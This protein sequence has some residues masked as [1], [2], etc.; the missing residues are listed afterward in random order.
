MI[1]N[2][3]L[4]NVNKKFVLSKTT[5]EEI[6]ST[7]LG[8]KVD[9][10][11]MFCNPLRVDN[12]PTCTMAY[13]NGKLLFRDWSYPKALDCF[14]FVMLKHNLNY[15]QALEKI[16]TDL[17]LLTRPSDFVPP[18][19]FIS[20]RAT[21]TGKTKKKL[22]QVRVQDFQFADV[23]YW[24]SYFI[25]RKILDKFKCF[26]INQMWIEKQ[27]QY[28]YRD[29][30]PAI[31]YFLGLDG[32]KDQ[33]WKVYFYK[34]RSGVRFIGNTNRINGWVQLPQF[35]EVLVIT[36]SMKDVMVLD[37]FG[38]PAIA[39]QSET[40][41]PYKE[42]IEDL[43]VRFTNIYSLYDF[44]YAGI[45]GALKIRQLYGIQPL[46]LTNGKFRTYNYEAK[47]ISDYIKMN[48]IDRTEDLI[49]TTS[50]NLGL[51]IKFEYDA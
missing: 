34:R 6:F 15:G 2:S 32:F 51:N 38:I 44:D 20:G 12:K 25:T 43:K 9:I 5:Q 31:G 21:L 47:D 50:I 49:N 37:C 29:E 33:K 24:K 39:M 46:F 22:I 40:T 1:H 30:D 10:D 8:I 23:A 41:M 18:E 36:K 3:D 48:G 42:I 14:D 19:I 13:F 4:V 17:E 35:G 27:S 26:S 28:I 11:Y 7:Y 16:V 45:K